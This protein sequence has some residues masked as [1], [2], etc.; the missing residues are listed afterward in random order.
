MRDKIDLRQL[1]EDEREHFEERA[2]ILE[3]DAGRP[4][5]IAESQAMRMVKEARKP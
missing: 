3:F 5:Q 1:S 2:A 4:R